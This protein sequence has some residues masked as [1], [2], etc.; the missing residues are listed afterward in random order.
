MTNAKRR[1]YETVVSFAQSSRELRDTFAA[2]AK[3]L[4]LAEEGA[5]C[6]LDPIPFFYALCLSYCLR[7]PAVGKVLANWPQM[8]AIIASFSREFLMFVTTRGV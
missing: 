5:E 4:R 1:E 8:F 2:F 3:Q 6:T 7:S